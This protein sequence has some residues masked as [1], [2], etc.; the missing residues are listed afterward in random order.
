MWEECKEPEIVKIIEFYILESIFSFFAVD[1]GNMQILLNS[2]AN[3]C[4]EHV[5]SS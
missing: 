4:T 3:I 2:S 1:T 5:F